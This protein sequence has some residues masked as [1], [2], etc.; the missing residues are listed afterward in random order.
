MEGI[1]ILLPENLREGLAAVTILLGLISSFLSFKSVLKAHALKIAGILLLLGLCLFANN[2]WSYFAGIFII[3]SAVTRTEYLQ[4]LAAIIRG[5]KEYFDYKKEFVSNQ[6]IFDHKL[7]EI[8]EFEQGEKQSSDDAELVTATPGG[9]NT[10]ETLQPLQ[11]ALIAEDFA[12]KEI[13]R[14]YNTP[15]QRHIR[16]T[17]KEKRLEFDGLLELKDK[18]VICATKIIP[19]DPFP[20]EPLTYSIQHILHETVE[21]QKIIHKN[22]KISISYVV[23]SAFVKETKEDL[24]KQLSKINLKNTS[25]EVEVEYLLFTFDELGIPASHP[26]TSLS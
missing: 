6:E 2:T 1:E 26:L 7:Q 24:I 11:L 13:E 17:T 4:N 21:Y 8:I 16:I 15:I 19:H 18:N 14:R 5:N 25:D 23:V 20:I 9:V 10:I 22:K 12:F 3:A